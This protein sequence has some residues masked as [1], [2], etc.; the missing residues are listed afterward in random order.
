M[1]RKSVIKRLTEALFGAEAAI[2]A[3][4]SSS[5]HRRLMGAQWGFKPQPSHFDHHIDLFYQWL[6]SRNSMWLERGVLSSLALK[7]G[8]VLELACGDGFNA[9][10]FYSLASRRVVGCDFDPEAIATARLKNSA[11]N[12]EYVVADMRSAMPEGSFEN[13]VWDFGFPLLD[14]FTPDEV[15]GILQQIKLR[16]G[17]DG[18]LSGYTVAQKEGTA[19]QAQYQFCSIG[20]L[21]DFLAPHFIHVTVFETISPGRCNLY[22]W[23]SDSTLPFMPDWPRARIS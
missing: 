1:S 14:Y 19:A 3:R 7:G 13:V 5:A 18:I 17:A 4:W 2:A 23:A 20:D 16:I 9:R 11:E 8:D 10:N 15:N 21:H 22:F 6:K 12:I